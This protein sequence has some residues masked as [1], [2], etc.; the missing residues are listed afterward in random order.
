VGGGGGGRWGALWVS[1]WGGGEMSV[2]L[3]WFG[4]VRLG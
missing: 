4:D 3:G 2:R 1:A